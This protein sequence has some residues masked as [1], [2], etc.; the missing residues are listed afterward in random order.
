MHAGEAWRKPRLELA[1]RRRA[2]MRAVIGVH[3]AVIAVRADR[4]DRVIVEED[5]PAAADDR[6]LLNLVAGRRASLLQPLDHA[7]EPL[8]IDR[9]QEVVE[10]LNRERVDRVALVGRHEDELRST[11]RSRT[12]RAASRPERP[13]ISM[14]QKTAW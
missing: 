8:G 3:A 10:R 6:E 13:C 2:E 9:F 1:Q 7:R 14:S 11:G 12:S 4:V 5:G